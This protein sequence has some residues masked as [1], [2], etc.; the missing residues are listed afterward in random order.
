MIWLLSLAFTVLSY[1]AAFLVGYIGGLAHGWTQGY[2]DA[3][4][5][6]FPESHRVSEKGGEG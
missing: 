2:G 6:R 1:A 3:A 4:D 5:Y